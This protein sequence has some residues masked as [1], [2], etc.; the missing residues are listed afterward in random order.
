MHKTD[1]YDKELSRPQVFIAPRLGN[2]TLALHSQT[3]GFPKLPFPSFVNHCVNETL[4]S[5][6]N[7]PSRRPTI[8]ILAEK[9]INSP[10][11]LDWTLEIRVTL[12]P[13][14]GAFGRTLSLDKENPR[15]WRLKLA[16]VVHTCNPTYYRGGVRRISS[17]RSTQAKLAERP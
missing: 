5:N 14:S 3:L 7:G 11:K 15:Q 12:F 4:L 9:R 8:L 17:S 13:L 10:R 6:S 1:Y 2:P 16:V